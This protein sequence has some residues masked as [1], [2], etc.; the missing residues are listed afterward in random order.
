M[1]NGQNSGVATNKSPADD[2]RIADPN[3]VLCLALTF[4]GLPPGLWRKIVRLMLDATDSEYQNSL[5]DMRRSNEFEQAKI[6]VWTDSAYNTFRGVIR[7]LGEG[8]IGPG[9]PLTSRRA[10]ML[11]AEGLGLL[12]RAGIRMARVTAAS[13]IIARV[14]IY[15][16]L[17]WFTGCAAYCGEM[18]YANAVTEFSK[19]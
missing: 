17:A 19:S 1:A 2:P 18:A 10:L 3:F 7:F 13:Q 9:I 11:R 14:N 15:L 8:V 6:A 12:A 4:I 16:E 5:S